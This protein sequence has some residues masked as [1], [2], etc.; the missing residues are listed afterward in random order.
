MTNPSWIEPPPKREPSCLKGCL[1]FFVF[2]VLGFVVL[3]ASIHYWGT[4]SHSA[5]SRGIYW[6]TKI[7][8]ISNKPTAIPSVN[9]SASERENVLER[10]KQF[11]QAGRAGQTAEIEL[12]AD[13]LNVLIAEDPD[14]EGKVFATIEG[15]QLRLQISVRLTQ[16]IVRAAQY[17]NAQVTIEAAEPQALDHP[18]LGRITVNGK[19]V[20]D[21][22]LEWRYG[23]RSLRD[24]AMQSA[25][26][27]R[28]QSVQIR[29]GKLVL[30]SR[31]D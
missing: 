14:V 26:T 13:D 25:E 24:Y 9:V 31:S 6:L 21:D 19:P 7:H 28:V 18:D 1:F 8:A 17:V 29:D 20:P 27:M 5:V 12:T 15:N 4:R 30:R 22:F 16:T 3:I 11:E 2:I 10:W 23:G